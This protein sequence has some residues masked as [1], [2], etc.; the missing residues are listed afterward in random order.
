MIRFRQWLETLQDDAMLRPDRYGELDPYEDEEEI[1]DRKN[2]VGQAFLHKGKYDLN[3]GWQQQNWNRIVVSSYRSPPIVQP[4]EGPSR[5]NKPLGGLWY[6]SGSSWLAH[7]HE[8]L[9]Q[10]ISMF[11][12][13]IFIDLS[14]VRVIN[15][16]Q[17]AEMFEEEFKKSLELN[18]SN[19]LCRIFYAHLLNI[20][21]RPDEALY[22]A[23]QAL[24]LDPQRP[25]ILGLYAA[26]MNQMGD[27]QSAINYNLK[28][29]SIGS[30]HRFAIVN[31]SVAYRN[32]GDYEKWFEEWKKIAGARYGDKVVASI[33]S[34]FQDEGYHATTKMILK[35]DEEAAKEKQINIG[36]QVN[37]YMEIKEYDKAMDW[38]EKGYEIQSPSMPYMGKFMI[39]YEQL[40]ENPRYIELLKKMKLPLPED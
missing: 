18:P 20:L 39:T 14:N 37:R 26:L 4:Y 10:R 21:S 23:N 25:F 5:Y 7:L 15:S 1:E 12:H 32:V 38:L 19:A 6:A 30:T 9:P 36:G 11:V 27:Y 13:Q 24:K 3:S 29:L 31:L 28:A 34:V 35:I 22:Q 16:D 33:D 8:M 40:K 2:A 17:D